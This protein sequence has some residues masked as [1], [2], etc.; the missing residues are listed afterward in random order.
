[1]AASSSEDSTSKGPSVLMRTKSSSA[2]RW[3]ILV[4]ASLLML[5][6]YYVYDVPAS[7]YV[8]FFCLCGG[9]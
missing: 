5:S 6:N 4:C 2:L 3:A 9:G 7:L 8:L 1:M